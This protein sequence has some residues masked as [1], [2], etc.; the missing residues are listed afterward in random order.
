[1]IGG[2]RANYTWT[3]LGISMG[4]TTARIGF[5]D[6]LYLPDGRVAERNHQLVE[7]LVEI[8]AIFGRRPA[9]SEEAREIMGL[10]RARAPIAR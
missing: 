1:V 3:T 8:A 4:C 10:N 2:G 6:G 5:E 9:T 7:K